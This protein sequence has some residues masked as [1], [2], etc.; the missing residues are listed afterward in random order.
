MLENEASFFHNERASAKQTI[1]NLEDVIEQL[2]NEQNERE[3]C[4]DTEN[5][6]LNIEI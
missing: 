5:E 6:K 1:A 2:I 3:Q 4:M